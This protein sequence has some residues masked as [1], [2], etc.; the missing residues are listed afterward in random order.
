MLLIPEEMEEMYA[1]WGDE[2][3]AYFD[4]REF[5]RDDPNAPENWDTRL[6]KAQHAKSTKQER[7]RIRPYCEDAIEVLA[8]VQGEWA[9]VTKTYAPEWTHPLKEVIE[10]ME[11]ALKES[12]GQ[13]G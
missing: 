6:I 2:V 5:K 8:N 12:D 7:E 4:E 10:F 11:Q 1:E 9:D 3:G 13:T